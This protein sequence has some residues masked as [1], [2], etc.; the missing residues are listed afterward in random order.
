MQ[1]V[2][3]GSGK[4]VG[5]GVGKGSGWGFVLN[6]IESMNEIRSFFLKTYMD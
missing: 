3:G 1:G 4:G 6:D 2:Q 5:K